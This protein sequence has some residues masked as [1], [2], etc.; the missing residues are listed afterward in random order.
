MIQIDEADSPVVSRL[1]E[2]MDLDSW[3]TQERKGSNV[4]L[5]FPTY[6]TETEFKDELGNKNIPFQPL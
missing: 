6:F 4:V 3:V 2:A 1:L 5:S